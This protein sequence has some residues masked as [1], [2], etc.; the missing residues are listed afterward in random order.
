MGWMHD[1]MD[2]PSRDP[3]HRSFHHNE[4]TFSAVYAWSE[5]YVLPLSH[6]E[7]VHGK[8]SLWQK[9]PGDG[10]NTASGLRCLLA[11]MWAH[12]GKQ[13]LFMGG[14]FGQP[15]EWSESRSLDWQ[16]LENPLHAGLLRLVTD[17]NA[18]YRSHGA[19]YE[20]DTD[21]AG[22]SWIDAN[23]SANNVLSFV[24]WGQGSSPVVCVANFAG[25]P[26]EN[27]RL[28]LPA[29][30]DWQELLNTDAESYGGSGVGNLGRVRATEREWHGLPASAAL[31]VP[32]GGVLWLTPAAP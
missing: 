6:D 24:R 2:Y 30:G 21:P 23:D 14:E 9:M 26:H 28:G 22:F 16:E 27:Y 19:L 7:V 12:P 31:R 32:P 20:L 25:V 17:L 10:W 15:R 3:V 1:T 5:N 18:A 11:Y 8:G 29:A 13:L 4:V